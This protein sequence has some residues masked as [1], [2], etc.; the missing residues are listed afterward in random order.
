MAAPQSDYNGKVVIDPITRIEGHLRIEVEVENGKVKDAWSS[1]TLFRGLEIILKG[2]DPRDAQ[3]FTQRSCGVCTYV[4]ALASTRCVDNAIGVK[5]PENATIMRNL[6]LASQ[7]LH[8][9][10]VHFYHL[11]ALDWVDVTNALNA[12]PKKAAE[13]ANSISPRPTKAEDLKAVQDKLKAFVDSGQ[14]GIF[15]NAYFLGGHP[16]YV[17]PAEVD[18]IATAHYLEALRLQVKAARAMAIFGAKN[19]HTQF[20]VAGGCTNYD[21]LRPERVAEFMSLFKETKKFV[22]EV[23]IPD[24]LAVASYYKDWAGIGGTTNFMSFGEFPTDEYD[25][26]SRYIPQGVLFD[27]DLSKPMDFNPDDIKEHVRYSWYE[28]S[29][30][31]HPYN[32]V[33]EPKYTDMHGDGRYSWMKAPRYQDKSIEVGPLATMLVGYAKGQPEIKKT[34]DMVLAH[35]NVGPEALFSTLG[36][37]AGRGI[38]TVVIANQIESWVNKLQANVSS[39]NTDL[40]TDWE[41]PKESEGVGFV[42]APRGGLSHWIKQKDGV[43]ENFQLV[44]PSTWNLGPRDE[45]GALS[46]VEEA[47]VGT[48]IA[49]PKRPVEVLRTVH[50]YDPCIACGVHIIDSESNETYKFKVL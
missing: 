14:L 33:T 22:D 31:R 23:Y 37:T 12:D 20:T 42:N 44:V 39:G 1:S 19:P 7:F 11:H 21:A 27:R 46:P 6:V 43:I 36:R 48:P 26:N 10:I 25:L 3:H 49:D 38:E 47:L 34:V 40:Y 32:G 45:S 2:R 24:L 8:D 29:E 16:A 35:L 15:T 18:L 4:H 9:H 5:I 28:G 30:A 50:S 13:I 41:W 17:L